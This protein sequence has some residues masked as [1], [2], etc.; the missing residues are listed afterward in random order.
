MTT[1][2]AMR[3][4]AEVVAELAAARTL[5]AEVAAKGAGYE[6]VDRKWTS[7][8]MVQLTNYINELVAELNAIDEYEAEQPAGLQAF[9]IIPRG[10]RH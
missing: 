10:S 4:R 9:G 2:S 8:N 6:A 3:P 7:H 5:R 1:P